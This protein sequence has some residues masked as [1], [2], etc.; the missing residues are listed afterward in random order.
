MCGH[1]TLT[2]SHALVV[3]CSPD[4]ENCKPCRQLTSGSDISCVHAQTLSRLSRCFGDLEAMYMARISLN[5]SSGGQTPCITRYH[6]HPAPRSRSRFCNSGCLLY[7]T[8]TFSTPSSVSVHVYV[9]VSAPVQDRSMRSAGRQS[10]SSCPM[11]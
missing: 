9:C 10:S 3:S 5:S 7:N 4:R 1:L 11:A 2:T 6:R 8:R